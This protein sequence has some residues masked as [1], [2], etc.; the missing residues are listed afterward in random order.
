MPPDS[1]G[2]LVG[3]KK[4]FQLE[5]CVG[6][7]AQAGRQAGRLLLT[8]LISIR[9]GMNETCCVVPGFDV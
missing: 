5:C 4:N 2:A 7:R 3:F 9:A 8:K 6:M 1:Y